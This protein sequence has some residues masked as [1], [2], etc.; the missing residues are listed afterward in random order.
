MSDN[1]C[2]IEG[3]D[4][5]KVCASMLLQT[6]LCSSVPALDAPVFT[7][8]PCKMFKMSCISCVPL[9]AMFTL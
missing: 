9:Y 7:A 2:I 3:R 6:R 4:S 8:S 5:V 1:F